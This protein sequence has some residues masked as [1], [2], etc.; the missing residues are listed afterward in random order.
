MFI[1][2]GLSVDRENLVLSTFYAM[3][4]MFKLVP[5][6]TFLTGLFICLLRVNAF[7]LSI[8]VVQEQ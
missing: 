5:V 4:D 6:V 2:S 8:Q 1:N 7:R 3:V